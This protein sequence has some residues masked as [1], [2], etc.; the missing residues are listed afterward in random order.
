VKRVLAV[1][2][3]VSVLLTACGASKPGTSSGAGSSSVANKSGPA[4][5][6]VKNFAFGPGNLTVSKGTKVT[7]KF[8]DTTQHNVTADDNKFKS[9][10]IQKGSYSY[11]F[12]SPG[13]YGYYCSIHQYMKG[14]VTVK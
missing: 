12:N 4:T 11:T 10:D 6:V 13:K 8:E 14:N 2:A 9:K 1:A 7:W 3:V 5:V